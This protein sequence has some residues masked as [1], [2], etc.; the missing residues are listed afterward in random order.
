M[1]VDAVVA[2]VQR[3]ILEPFDRNVLGVVGGVLDLAEGLYPVD[4]LGLLGPE[5][6]RILD[7]ARV[8]ILVLGFVY[9]GA[10][11]PVGGHVI[12]L[13]RHRHFLP[14]HPDAAGAYSFVSGA[15]CDGLC[16]T[17]KA[18]MPLVL[19]HFRPQGPKPPTMAPIIRKAPSHA[20][21]SMT[22]SITRRSPKALLVAMVVSTKPNQ[23][24]AAEMMPARTV[25]AFICI[26]MP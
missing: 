1:A 10:F 20:T 12:K 22:V 9:V 26:R 2:D 8:K 25:K 24:K 13:F 15:L 4:A 7:R 23:Q 14:T 21:P 19:R 11:A 3:A 6:V 17:D 16:A 18:R 5:A